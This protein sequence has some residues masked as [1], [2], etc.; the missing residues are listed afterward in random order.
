MI[1]LLKCNYRILLFFLKKYRSYLLLLFSPSINTK[2]CE[3]AVC[4]L[5]FWQTDG[6]SICSLMDESEVTRQ[7]RADGICLSKGTACIKAE[8]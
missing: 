8:S 5:N 6:W 7:T 4:Q 1:L 2:F 3:R